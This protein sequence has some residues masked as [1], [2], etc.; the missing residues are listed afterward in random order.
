M[1]NTSNLINGILCQIR[2]HTNDLYPDINCST[3]TEFLYNPP[4]RELEELTTIG[5]MKIEEQLH[6]SVRVS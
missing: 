2:S 3:V 5:N 4:S 1:L 6:C